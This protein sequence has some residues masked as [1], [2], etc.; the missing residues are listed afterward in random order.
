MKTREALA[1]KARLALKSAAAVICCAAAVNLFAQ[2]EAA[3]MDGAEGQAVDALMK[4]YVSRH[5]FSG[6]VLVAR[7][8]D[9]LFNGG[10]GYAR[11]YAGKR[12]NTVDTQFVLGSM[13]KNFTA[14]AV[15]RLKN[16]GYLRLDQSITEFFPEY[17]L[18]SGVTIHH[19]LNH[20]SGIKNYYGSGMD[21]ARYFLGHTTP[22]QIMAEYKNTPLLFAPGSNFDYSNTNYM[23]LS[24]L[25]EKLSGKS[26][27]EYL[28]EIVLSPRGMHSTG[29]REDPFTIETMAKGYCMN[30]VV[31]INGFN[32][33]NFYGAGGLYS[34][35]MDLYLYLSRLDERELSNDSAN[36]EIA[37]WP[38]N[39]YG[40]GMMFYDN[41]DYGR[42]YF[43]TGGGPGIST[44]MFKLVDKDMIV[45][46]L[47]NN[48]DTDTEMIAGEIYKAIASAQTQQ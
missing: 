34:S 15:M 39:F 40:Y 1:A 31:E 33:S 26:Y 17:T 23:I 8:K 14:L 20:T 29:Y 25:I 21:F 5:G 6:S 30:M 41:P 43:I 35:T 45:I 24:A 2:T 13:T 4:S 42:T 28:D 36:V 11:R 44:G 37:R 3:G 32:L 7:G 48:Q 47:S 12:E 16:S 18:W 38:G 19:L 27:I 9:I 10:Y 22:L 46:V